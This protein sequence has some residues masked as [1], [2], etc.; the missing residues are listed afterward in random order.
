MRVAEGGIG[1]DNTRVEAS[2]ALT[3]TEDDYVRASQNGD[4]S[5]G[6]YLVD[7]HWSRVH[8][9]AYRLCMNSADAEDITQET[10]LRALKG[11]HAYKPDGQ[12][13]SWLF[14]IATNLYL[15]Q[16]K[17]LRNRDVVTTEMEKE[18]SRAVDP[19][20]QEE[21]RELVHALLEAMEELS[22]EQ[23]VV[24]LLRAIEHMDYPAIASMLSTKESTTRWHMY[25]ARRI[26]RQKLSRRFDLEGLVDE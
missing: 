20:G 13:K 4:E 23:K 5:A 8:A 25:E 22:K 1:L 24:V 7:L 14:R 6:A 11:I 9:F 18:D 17:A 12:F 3:K 21:Q 15:D 2:L 26:L 16:K 10:F 19:V